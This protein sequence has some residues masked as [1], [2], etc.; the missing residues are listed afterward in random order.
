MSFPAVTRMPSR[1]AP[2]RTGALPRSARPSRAARS[3]ADGGALRLAAIAV[4]V[5]ACGPSGGTG[6]TADSAHVASAQ[7]AM[8]DSVPRP[9]AV[10]TV[11]FRIPEESEIRDSVVLASIRRGRA[12]LTH[13]GDSLPRNVGNA[14][15]CTNCHQQEGTLRD[16]MPWVG[17]Y[18]R[19]P[20]YRSRGGT[21]IIIEDRVNDCFKRSMNGKPLD[22]ESREMRDIVAYFAFLSNGVPVGAQVEGQ[23]LPK[24]DA[25]P[26]DTARGAQLF[27]MRCA[28]CH[29]VAGGGTVLAPPLWGNRSYNIGAGMARVRTAAAF[30]KRWMPQDSAGVLSAQEAFDVATYVDSRPRPDFKG[31]EKDWP[32]GDAPPD[33]AYP[34]DAARRKNAANR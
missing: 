12:I 8:S 32:N 11:A 23:G 18:A 31:K 21:T 15:V 20:Q 1:P 26:G 6:A 9:R 5:T 10:A 14:L 22:P 30:I 24:L 19:F 27:T 33:V 3:L 29:G 7:Q 4:A 2:A 17:V 28:R 13:T 16:A 25:L 34:T